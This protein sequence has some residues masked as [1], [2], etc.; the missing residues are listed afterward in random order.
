VSARSFNA[1]EFPNG[2]LDRVDRRVAQARERLERQ[3]EIIEKLALGG[4]DTM[5]AECVLKVMRRT[6]EN[7]ENDRRAIE[8]EIFAAKAHHI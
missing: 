4:H 3:R 1:V 2:D 8:D 5:D 6:L 7:F